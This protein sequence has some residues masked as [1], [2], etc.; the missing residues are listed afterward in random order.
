MQKV[1]SIQVTRIVAML[2]IIICHLCN[3]SNNI[4]INYL[5]QF[6]N[7]GVFVFLFLSGYLHANKKIDKFI[8]WIFIKIK[9]IFLPSLIFSLVIMFLNSLFYDNFSIYSFFSYIF[10]LQYFFGRIMGIGHLWFVSIIM[11]CYLL[12]PLLNKKDAFKI[13]IV[14]ILLS[15]FIGFFNKSISLLGFY[16]FTF[17][18]GYI[19]KKENYKLNYGFLTFA[20][21]IIIRILGKFILDDS[22]FYETTI[23]SVSHIL[24]SLSIFSVINKMNFI[25]N[26]KIVDYLDSMSYYIFIVHYP[27]IDG[28]LIILNHNIFSI[29]LFF[30][31]TL[32]FAHAL[33]NVV[34][35]INNLKIPK[36]NIISIIQIIEIFLIVL[37]KFLLA[38][39]YRNYYILFPMIFVIFILCL[40]VFVKKIKQI[41]LNDFIIICILSL[42]SSITM[43]NMKSVNFVFPVMIAIS[44]YNDDYKKIG[45]IFFH[46]LTICFILTLFLNMIDILPDHN[47]SRYDNI[48]YAMGFMNVAFVMLYYTG[49][50]VAYY[51][52]YGTSKKFM[53][54]SCFFGLVLYFLS[55]S[56]TGII[57]LFLFLLVLIFNKYLKK[58]LYFIIPHLYQI[59]IIFSFVLLCIISFDLIPLPIELLDKFLSGRIT[60]FLYYFEN[61]YL[62]TLFGF[63]E[64]VP[65]ALDCYY[66]FPLLRFGIIGTIIYILLNYFSLTKLKNNNALMIAQLIILTYGFGDSNVVV[67]SINCLLS[68]QVLSLINKTNPYINQSSENFIIETNI[69]QKDLISIIVP[70]YNAQNYLDKC[71]NSII[72]QSYK[73]IEIIL[74]ND[75]STDNSK[76]ICDKYIKNDDRI[77][78]INQNNSGVSKSRNNGLKKANGKYIVFVDSD[79]FL[80]KN[81]ILKLY[82]NVKKHGIAKCNYYII[83]KNKTIKKEELD[84]DISSKEFINK[85]LNNEVGGFIWSWMFEKKLLDNIKFKEDLHYMEDSLFLLNVLGKVKN[86][87]LVSDCLYGYT[88][89]QSSITNNKNKIKENISNFNKAINQIQVLVGD[90]ELLKLKKIILVESNC[91]LLQNKEDIKEF[92]SIKNLDK[93]FNT[94]QISLRYKIFKYLVINKISNGL[95]VYCKVR[96]IIKKIRSLL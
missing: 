15:I 20:I 53:F 31:L 63:N 39:N 84:K 41:K 68:I 45:K 7:V 8:T 90:S 4:F 61:G 27:F 29:I 92:L 81:M 59:L 35:Y 14:L 85:Y 80:D 71:L 93:M 79:D 40:I 17:S 12:L 26:N 83:K 87:A 82:K 48:R 57:T 54:M 2:F 74:I 30:V 64:R 42:L 46:S 49:I 69:E 21:A 51:I 66:L 32:I 60:A 72:N 88:I 11:I 62:T 23:S 86:I 52:G 3:Y 16:L 22:Y 56:R 34:D 91:N 5:A 38:Y 75:G 47:L 6:F 1:V 58:L 25:K 65:V 73:K 18:L 43:I 76:E 9:K 89:N 44:F 37:Y 50:I 28:P 13:S 24:I 95:L 55:Y 67:S 70:V 36:L 33:K 10:N 19:F 94:N 96:K 77:I 78:L